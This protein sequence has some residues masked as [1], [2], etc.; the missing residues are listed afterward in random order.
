[1]DHSAE[2]LDWWFPGS[3]WWS[4][5]HSHSGPFVFPADS[6]ETYGYDVHRFFSIYAVSSSITRIC[7]ISFPLMILWMGEMFPCCVACLMLPDFRSWNHLAWCWHKKGS[8]STILQAGGKTPSKKKKKKKGCPGGIKMA[9]EKDV[10]LTF[11]HKHNKKKKKNH[12]HVEQFIQNIYWTLTEYLKPSKRAK[13]PLHN[14]IEQKGKK[15]NQEGTSTPVRELW[16]RKGTQ[17]LGSHLTDGEISRSRGTSKPRRKAQQLDWG[18]QNR[19]ITA[20]RSV[21]LPLDT[22]A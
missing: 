13:T 12:L 5:I 4:I 1:M 2:G 21:P 9:E 15:R 17:T 8:L 10:V 18:G 19:E 16:K 20:Q 6:R 22:T 11:S 14:W 3:H 7:R